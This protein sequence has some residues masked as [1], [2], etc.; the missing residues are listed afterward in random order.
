MQFSNGSTYWRAPEMGRPAVKNINAPLW[1]YCLAPPRA[2]GGSNL[3]DRVSRALA[4][5]P[6]K[7][8]RALLDRLGRRIDPSPMLCKEVG[9]RYLR[10]FFAV[11]GRD[12]DI[13]ESTII[14][15]VLLY[16]IQKEQT[17]Y[18]HPVFAGP[19]ANPLLKNLDGP[20]S[21]PKAQT[22]INGDLATRRLVAH[23]RALWTRFESERTT[24]GRAAASRRWREGFHWALVRLYFCDRC[25]GCRWGS[26]FFEGSAGAPYRESDSPP[27]PPPHHS[28]ETRA[29]V[30]AIVCHD[31]W[32]LEVA[33]AGRG[34]FSVEETPRIVHHLDQRFAILVFPTDVEF[35]EAG[36]IVGL[37]VY[38]DKVAD[39]VW[40]VHAL[41]AGPDADMAFLH[42]NLALGLP[43]IAPESMCAEVKQSHQ[44][45]RRNAWTRFWLDE[46]EAGIFLASRHWLDSHWNAL[47]CFIN[48]Q[49]VENLENPVNLTTVSG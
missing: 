4:S 22:G 23:K 27:A 5:P 46:L 35:I 1:Q 13:W 41:T 6:V 38:Y 40:Y 3:D 28:F 39:R 8:H 34:G 18:A 25:D 33:Y 48:G 42:G 14:A 31:L 11:D 30:E 12:D 43:A 45:W 36:S 15:V 24:L 2:V 32:K 9:D 20:M 49:C 47:R 44:D 29:L 16:D 37:V 17:L 10:L 21:A 26:P 7:A 19:N